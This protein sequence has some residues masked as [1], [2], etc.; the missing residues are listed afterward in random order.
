MTDLHALYAARWPNG[1]PGDLGP[2]QLAWC[3][4]RITGFAAARAAVLASRGENKP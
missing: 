4:E 3:E 2:K 1:R